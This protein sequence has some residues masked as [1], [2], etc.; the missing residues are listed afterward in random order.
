MP[1]SRILRY[2]CTSSTAIFNQLSLSSSCLSIYTSAIL[3]AFCFRILTFPFCTSS[4]ATFIL[5][6]RSNVSLSSSATSAEISATSSSTKFCAAAVISRSSSSASTSCFNST[7]SAAFSAAMFT[8]SIAFSVCTV[9]HRA[10]DSV[11]SFRPSLYD[12]IHRSTNLPTTLLPNIGSLSFRIL[13]GYATIS[14]PSDSPLSKVTGMGGARIIF[15]IALS[16][17]AMAYGLDTRGLTSV[18]H[19]ER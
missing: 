7:S 14:C 8:S 4:A 12:E 3:S 11:S 13:C 16:P 1:R 6:L 9:L 15:R 19:M 18:P 17:C 2:L 5:L 10:F